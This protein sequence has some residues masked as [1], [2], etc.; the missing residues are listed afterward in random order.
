MFDDSAGGIIVEHLMG[1]GT[2]VVPPVLL[3]MSIVTQGT[4]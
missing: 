4:S 1:A 2:P 3:P